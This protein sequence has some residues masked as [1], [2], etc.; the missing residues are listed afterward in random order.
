L[1]PTAKYLSFNYTDTLERYYG[2]PEA[3]I[4]YIHNKA[5]TPGVV[6]V[7]G[8]GIDPVQFSDQEPEPPVGLSEDDLYYW[9]Q[10]QADNFE[11]SSDMARDE[12]ISY[13]TTSHKDTADVI[14]KHQLFFDE[15]GDI[16]HIIVLGHSLAPVDQPYIEKILAANGRKATWSVSYYKDEEMDSHKACLT[17][18]GL[19]DTQLDFFKMTDLR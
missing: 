11:L 5:K 14:Q 2:V 10:E 18:L 7:L 16:Q 12:I 17:G 15:L 1:E 19:P 9:R 8:H 3:N 4:T 13:F 6:L